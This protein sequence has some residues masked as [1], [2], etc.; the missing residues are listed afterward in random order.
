M[1]IYSERLHPLLFIGSNILSAD[2]W[3]KCL[4]LLQDEYS[5]QQ[6]H[7]WLR[8]LQAHTDEQRL[9][10]LAPN[11]FIV[12]W[13]KKNFFSRIEE[14][15]QQ[16]RGDEIKSISIEIGSKTKQKRQLRLWMR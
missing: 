1:N 2:V 16:F 10:L 5:D 6:F 11:R 15:I 7:T 13:V 4:S 9:V 12:D 14:L 3:Q 8:P